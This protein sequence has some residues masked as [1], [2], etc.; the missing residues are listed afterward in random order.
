MRLFGL[1][2]MCLLLCI[3]CVC[4]VYFLCILFVYFT[5]VKNMRGN[6]KTLVKEFNKTEDDLKAL[7]VRL[8]CAWLLTTAWVVYSLL[9]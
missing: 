7:Q 1:V 5:R 3:L 2:I 4:H 9:N 6:V 8:A